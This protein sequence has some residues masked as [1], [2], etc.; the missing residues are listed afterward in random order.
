M[1]EEELLV[2]GTDAEWHKA[3]VGGGIHRKRL[4]P[5]FIYK[6]NGGGIHSELDVAGAV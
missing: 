4:L 3:K 1:E 2:G 6:A 5:R